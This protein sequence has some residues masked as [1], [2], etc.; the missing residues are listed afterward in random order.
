VR[1]K[2]SLAAKVSAVKTL[3]KQLYSDELAASSCPSSSRITAPPAPEDEEAW[4]ETSLFTFLHL[5]AGF[6]MS[7]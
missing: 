7:A 6:A 3:P 2:P 4:N 1:S 5:A